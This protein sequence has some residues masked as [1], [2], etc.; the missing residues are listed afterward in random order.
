MVNSR[1]SQ[2]IGDGR[3]Y[4]AIEY[5]PLFVLAFFVFS[6]IGLTVLLL[7]SQFYSLL[8]LLVLVSSLVASYYICKT[9]TIPSRPGSVA[10]KRVVDIAVLIGV[11][12]WITV[13]LTL[14]S[15]STFV[16]RDPAI[17]SANGAWLTNNSNLRI[18]PDNSFESNLV[19]N[20]SAG[21]TEKDGLIK[22]QSQRLLSI[23]FSVL[24]RF[25]GLA[26]GFKINVVLGGLALLVF[27]GFARLLGR[28]EWAGL[29]TLCLG[30]SLP[31]IYFSR[32]TFTEP[33]TMLFVF[34]A[35]TAL[36]ATQASKKI[37][38]TQHIFAGL[39]LGSVTLARVDG[40]LV[41]IT[42]SFALVIQLLTNRSS[43]SKLSIIKVLEVFTPGLVIYGL[44][45]LDLIYI[46]NSYQSK[47]RL[48]MNLLL[49]AV[50]GFGLLSHILIQ[51]TNVQTKLKRVLSRNTKWVLAI[52]IIALAFMLSRP[53]W[54][55]SHHQYSIP[56]V[57]GLQRAVGQQV[58]ITRDYAENTMNW[59]MWY[60]GPLIVLMGLVG[61]GLALRKITNT[62]EGFLYL[63]STITV[64]AV[65][66]LFLNMPSITPDQIWA[67]RRFLPVIIPGLAAFSV[68]FLTTAYPYLA[69]FKQV[70]RSA[71]MVCLIFCTI[72]PVLY[73]GS[74]FLL[75]Q[76]KSSQLS[77][78]QSI[79]NTVEGT[80]LA[81]VWVGKRFPTALQ[82]VRSYCGVGAVGIKQL[83]ERKLNYLEKFSKTSGK[84]IYLL[85]FDTDLERAN[86]NQI[87]FQ[88]I[89]S[90]TYH[91]IPSKLT[92]PPRKLEVRTKT[93]YGAKISPDG[94][95][96]ILKRSP[97]G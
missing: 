12:V 29:A 28:S 1:V 77:Q 48:K 59:L 10:S 17:Y 68:L 76:I 38:T 89:S 21:F 33:L 96:N 66:A 55:V 39:A 3:L 34:G 84:V 69:K 92:S 61:L 41:L 83:D 62:K 19:S 60:A 35:L 9:F 82:P 22:P 5:S 86:T 7:L 57:G 27:Y 25:G 20:T 67:M 88:K 94:N 51:N 30:V 24:S 15:Q 70:K 43:H 31:Y 36:W 71:L 14:V 78:M 52:F 63:P 45:L 40:L 54:L 93:I 80:E 4:S 32:D 90:I 16:Y 50:I 26:L 56:L 6:S 72:A 97:A 42:V 91:S 44:S 65:S 81:V 53:L 74:P 95:P 46:G 37:K 13:N 47:Q 58:D 8:I 11:V 49:L 73:I 75:E 85:A 2:L 79:C 23:Y 64:L 87:K 18:Y